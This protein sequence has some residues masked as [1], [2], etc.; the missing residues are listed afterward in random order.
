MLILP[1]VNKRRVM[2]VELRLKTASKVRRNVCFDDAKQS[3]IIV[4]H[5]RFSDSSFYQ[6]REESAPMD[7]IRS[8][9]LLYPRNFLVTTKQRRNSVNYDVYEVSQ[10]PKKVSESL[11]KLYGKAILD[12]KN[13]IPEVKNRG[14]YVSF[15][16]LGFDHDLSD[17]KIARLQHIVKEERD[18]SKWPELFQK[19]GIADLQETID[20]LR[21]FDCC[22]LADNTMAEDS[23][24]DTLKS[25]EVINTRDYRNLKR[26]YDMAKSNAD[27]YTKLSYTHKVIYNKPFALIRAKQSDAK[28]LIKKKDEFEYQQVS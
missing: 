11:D 14:R 15:K 20:F 10:P 2:N 18:S 1:I 8:R 24:Q 5:A 3:E 12:L 28:Q 23:L 27:I 22:V 21:L 25:M 19:S 16:E 9:S 13:E 26:Y 6:S 7:F 17:D 4:N